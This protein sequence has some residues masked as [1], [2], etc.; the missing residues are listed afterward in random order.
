[1]KTT[2]NASKPRLILGLVGDRISNGSWLLPLEKLRW[3]RQA[4]DYLIVEQCWTAASTAAT[5]GLGQAASP[6][7]RAGP[8]GIHRTHVSR[9]LFVPPTRN[10]PIS[11]YL[12]KLDFATVISP[13]SYLN[14]KTIDITS[15]FKV[16]LISEVWTYFSNMREN[17][18]RI[19]FILRDFNILI[20]RIFCWSK[21]NPLKNYSTRF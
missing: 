9:C 1:M 13:L 2:R 7:R 17:L 21:R 15:V 10:E 4:T 18:P 8:D 11:D 3:R 5:A 19:S 6:R 16:R 20:P 12:P 14:K